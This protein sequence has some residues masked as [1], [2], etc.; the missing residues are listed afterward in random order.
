MGSQMKGDGG[1]NDRIE[2]TSL[3]LHGEE[4]QNPIRV[5]SLKGAVARMH[6]AADSDPIQLHCVGSELQC[7]VGS[8]LEEQ[9]GGD[10]TIEEN[11][12]GN[13]QGDVSPL[14]RKMSCIERVVRGVQ[15]GDYHSLVVP[16]PK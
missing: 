13:G 6:I 10:S 2:M 7:P 14:Q 8:E 1:G 12:E 4:T 16:L 11:E 9:G 5:V 3:R 15:G